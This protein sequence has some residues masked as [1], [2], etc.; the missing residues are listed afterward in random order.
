MGE[1]STTS[2]QNGDAEGGTLSGRP[3][4]AATAEQWRGAHHHRQFEVMGAHQAQHGTHFAVWAPNA[5]SVGV[6]GSFNNWTSQPLHRIDEQR[7]MVR[8]G[9]PV[10]LPLRSPARHGVASVGHL[11]HMG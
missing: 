2:A 9:R 7:R 4:L 6:I 5:R 10:R 11:A 1:Y 3:G 8:Q